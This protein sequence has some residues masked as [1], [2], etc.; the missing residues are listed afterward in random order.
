MQIKIHYDM[1]RDRYIVRVDDAGRIVD[2]KRYKS[3]RGVTKAV[4][5]L[6]SEGHTIELKELDKIALD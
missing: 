3:V 2:E 1:P 4:D 5:Q 6:R